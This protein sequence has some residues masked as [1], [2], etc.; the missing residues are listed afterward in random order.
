MVESGPNQSESG[1]KQDMFIVSASVNESMAT[2]VVS[3]LFLGTRFTDHL[4]LL[5]VD[6]NWL[7]V[8]K[9]FWGVAESD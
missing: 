5:K 3:N 1:V 4:C 8:N 9:S 7:I 2:V 6:D